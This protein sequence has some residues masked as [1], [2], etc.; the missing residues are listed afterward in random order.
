[1]AAGGAVAGRE[2]NAAFFLGQENGL[3]AQVLRRGQCQR[4]GSDKPPAPAQAQGARH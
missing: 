2:G 1:V 4:L 3:Q